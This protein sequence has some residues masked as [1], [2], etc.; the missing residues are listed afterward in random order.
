MFCNL[1][2]V[3]KAIASHA[4]YDHYAQCA[5]VET[6]K[7]S[8]SPRD[9]VDFNNVLLA[10]QERYL[11]PLLRSMGN[12]SCLPWNYTSLASM[13]P[14]HPPCNGNLDDLLMATSK[15]MDQIH[16]SCG[17]LYS[18]LQTAGRLDVH[19]RGNK[20]GGAFC[21]NFS[22]S[23]IPFIFGNFSARLKDAMTLVH[24]FGHAYHS[25]LSSFI[26][27]HLLRTPSMEFCEFAAS[28]FEL[29]ALEHL[30]HW[31]KNPSHYAAAQKQ[32]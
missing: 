3:R 32:Q 10:G 23:K 11:A 6:G 5:F 19:P 4:G 9:S 18:D 25:H 30:K 7:A 2:E 12:D 13:L 26:A 17:Q 16:P 22:K 1:G 29:L 28:S 20:A 14:G 21:V 31:Y 24:E 8:Y 27:N 15:M